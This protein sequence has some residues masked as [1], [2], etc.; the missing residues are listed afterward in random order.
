M[1]DLMT[2]VRRIPIAVGLAAAM[3]LGGQSALST[4]AGTRTITVKDDAFTPKKVTISK[5]T[6]V[7]WR[8]ASDA[9]EHVVVSR[10]TRKFKRSAIKEGGTHKVR[11]KKA[12]TYR[13][14]CTLHEEDGMTGQVVVR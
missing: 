5:N 7:T 10:G 3:A 13:Y 6:L 9:G 8:W 2:H 12:G 14:V 1:L 4:A 11:F